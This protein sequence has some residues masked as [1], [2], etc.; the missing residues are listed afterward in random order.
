MSSK[1]KGQGRRG[2]KSK[3]NNNDNKDNKGKGRG[4]KSKKENRS[5]PKQRSKLSDYIFQVG[6][7]KQASDFVV[8]HDYL[9]RY[10]G[11]HFNKAA[12]ISQALEEMKHVTFTEPVWKV[13]TAKDAAQKE[14]ETEKFRLDYNIEMKKFTD[15]KENY[16]NNSKKAY[17]FLWEQC[18]VT[19]RD[20][21]ES[22][23]GFAANI[24][25]DP[26]ELLKAIKSFALA[27]QETKYPVLSID[28]AHDAFV[29]T[30]QKPDEKL[31]DYL[32]RFKVA[33]DMME[34]QMGH[35]M[36]LGKYSAQLQKDPNVKLDKLTVVT[37]PDYNVEVKEG[38]SPITVEHL[39]EANERWIALRYLRSL[40][41]NKYGSLLKALAHQF[42]LGTDQYPKSLEKAHQAAMQHPWDSAYKQKQKQKADK[43]KQTEE[44]E[45]PDEDQPKLT[46]SQFS[47]KCA[48][49]GKQGHSAKDCYSKT[50]PRAQWYCETNKQAKQFYQSFAQ[51]V[52]LSS[53]AAA[54]AAAAPP[55]SVSVG[56]Q[57]SSNE[58]ASVTNSQFSWQMAQYQF[59]QQDDYLKK[60]EV[61]DSA[62]SVDLFCNPAMVSNIRGAPHNLNLTTSAGQ[63]LI[64]QE[65]DVRNYGRVWFDRD[66][67]ANIFALA[68][69]VRRYRVTFDSA[70]EDAFLVHTKPNIT[71]FVKD[72]VTN[73]Y[74][75]RPANTGLL[76]LTPTRAPPAGGPGGPAA[77]LGTVL[78]NTVEEN[79]RFHTPRE[80][81][82]AKEA[83]KL[84]EICGSSVR[85]LKTVILSNAIKNNPVTTK[86]VSLAESIF[87]K[88]IGYLKGHTTRHRPQPLVTDQVAIPKELRLRL[89]EIEL[90]MDGIYVNSMP[91]LTTISKLLMYRTAQ[92]SKTVLMED[93]LRTLD[94]VLRLYNSKGFRIKKIW[95]DNQ[96]KP[97]F[98]TCQDNMD[99]EID[100]P[101]AKDHVPEAERNNRSIKERVRAAFHRLPY[102]A[103][104]TTMM[105]HLV[106]DCATKMNW[107]PNKH[108][109][110]DHL[111]PRMI[112]SREP[113]DFKKHCV[114]PFGQYVQAS[115]EPKESEK[116]TNVERTMDALYIRPTS[117]GHEV[118]NLITQRIVT[119]GKV[120]PVP[121]TPSVI[122]TV[123]AI[124][125][126][127]KQKGLRIKTRRGDVLFD[128]SWIAGVDYDD[129]DDEED[130]YVYQ[131]EED[132]PLDYDTEDT[133]P[134]SQ[135]SDDSDDSDAGTD[136]DSES[137]DEDDDE[138]SLDDDDPNHAIT[139]G[140]TQEEPDEEPVE[141]DEPVDEPVE[142]PVQ[143]EE[144]AD[145]PR[146]ST[147]HNIGVSEPPLN[148]A[149]T[150]GQ[151]YLNLDQPNDNDIALALSQ[152]AVNFLMSVKEGSKIYKFTKKGN[153]FLTT[154][155]FKKGLKKFGQDGFNSA[156]KEMGQLHNRDCWKPIDPSTITPTE[157][158]KALQSLIFLVQKKSGVIKSRHCAN[159][160][161]QR[162]WID[163]R[164]ASSPTV[165]TDSVMLTACIEA[166]EERDVATVDIPNAFI[167]TEIDERDKD[168]DRV[169]MKIQGPMVDL[170]IQIDPTYEDF[171]VHERG[172]KTL[173][174]HIL[175]ALYGLLESALRYY[176]KW[177][178]DLESYGFKINPYDICVANKMV[179]NAQMTVSWHVDDVKVSHINPNHVDEF[180]A[181][182]T[183]EYGKQSP[184]T[185]TRGKKHVY[186]GMTLDYSK[187]GAVIV[188][189]RDYVKDMLEDFPR[190]ISGRV[191]S[192][193]T[194][195]LF[196]VKPSKK[197]LKEQA[198]AF[199][200]FVA[201]ALFLTKRA[202]PD[203][204]H[205]VSF[206]CTRVKEPTR[207]DWD[208]LVR[209][210]T[211]LHT[212][213]HECLTSELHPIY[214]KGKKFIQVIWNVDAAFAVH[215]DLKSH[216]G[217]ICTL[218]E[219]AA[220]A[221]SRKHKTNTRSST[222]AEIVAVDDVITP[223]IWSKRFLEAQGYPTKCI[224]EQDNQSTLKWIK[225]GRASV[226]K[227]T[228]HMDI[229]YFYVT[230]YVLKGI[231]EAKYKPT[232]EMT[233]DYLSKPLQGQLMTKHRTK[234]MNLPKPNH[235]RLAGVET[236]TTLTKS[237][238]KTPHYKNTTA[239][240]LSKK[241]RPSSCIPAVSSNRAVKFLK[242]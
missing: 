107:F 225:N 8:V 120:T 174:V 187:K 61:L 103:L 141:E 182:A 101:P 227:R 148:I 199:H 72:P 159:G 228:R 68:N 31:I 140:P 231:I 151:S 212:T 178:A 167:Q 16:E 62:S 71:K 238:L 94:N 215:D 102:K 113:L 53:P 157:R 58:A 133:Q 125:A 109:I 162:S 55:S 161:V 210:M 44:T 95:C 220:I 11:I 17:K 7:A 67:I 236:K 129:D 184:L 237:I 209:M 40:D 85:D 168:G 130:E 79:M 232:K 136:S 12:D 147:R 193:A 198:E 223:I 155:S 91:F 239:R 211:F 149:S 87:G 188:D 230:D 111:S 32:K 214:E 203:I 6:T 52:F 206:L 93:I 28:D 191:A 75:H 66:G 117:T 226:G 204:Q 18:S 5:A 186:L 46:F 190:S 99:L 152:Y 4:N 70:Q 185:V 192:C 221:I 115:D 69:M 219:G 218:G 36:I 119:R 97:M 139:N 45:K 3:S 134:E 216:T 2:G 222:A 234:I 154:Y 63:T 224:L 37:P 30:S 197:L 48:C 13:S 160:S 89:Q 183:A 144:E 21:V 240:P 10:V 205:V 47:N 98:A 82:Q 26:V 166:E 42:S 156:M 194:S 150:S 57:D 78:A 175:R 14:Q 81:A 50:K 22:I 29:R 217:A 146:R 108:G 177:R 27:F 51:A 143:D 116:N 123:E 38:K 132:E 35:E 15:K 181:W 90:F 39:H 172:V 235:A 104:P 145:E 41:K 80:I 164:E 127:Q 100:H 195:A 242:Q 112:L 25:E 124:A 122:K 131:E 200:T 83:R 49:C 241:L 65:A 74:V 229:R 64:K 171:V 59:I 76:Q 20:R 24:K 153:S 114:C 189:M 19:M 207:Q 135:D 105:I 170:L 179:D 202:R 34:S 169:I 137:S 142:E 118:Y 86:Q 43:N 9:A 54:A 126:S 77:H 208:K 60:A 96:F 84:L 163:D 158:K 73:L 201:K 23:P 110:S 165:M 233:G 92:H 213:K 88:D 1:G 33:R 173:Y 128:S 106:Q 196:T 121:V 180:I 138:D 56:A 176:Q